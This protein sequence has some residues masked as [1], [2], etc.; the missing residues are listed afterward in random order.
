M[1]DT[2]LLNLLD[3]DIE[4]C[5]NLADLLEQEFVALSERNLEELQHLLTQKQPLLEQLARN[6][7]KRSQTLTSQGYSADSAGFSAMASQLPHTNLLMVSHDR[8][9]QL[10]EQCQEAN[11]RNGRLIRTNQVNVGKALDI[12]RN[13]DGPSLYD[14][15]GSTAYKGTQRSFTR[16]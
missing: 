4:T 11:L 10:M 5:T 8:L 7:N 12:I 6:S 13:N 14:S 15:S 3:A 9:R 1:P 16:A 2:A